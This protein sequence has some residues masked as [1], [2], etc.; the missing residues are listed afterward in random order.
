MRKFDTLTG[1]VA[2]IALG[3]IGCAPIAASS[4]TDLEKHMMRWEGMK[5]NAYRDQ[6]GVPTICVGHTSDKIYPVQMGETWD[7]AK[8]LTVLRHDIS[9]AQAAIA[10]LVTVPLTDGQRAALTSFVFNVG[11]G[12]FKRSTLLQALNLGLYEDV[13][14]EL[15]RWNKVTVNGKKR[16]SNG[17]VNRREAEVALWL[18]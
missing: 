8:C 6:A 14:S 11:V 13:P 17:L 15:R 4:Y 18:S 7:K 16:V 10:W 1:L 2:G 12:A 9:E 5:L 3:V